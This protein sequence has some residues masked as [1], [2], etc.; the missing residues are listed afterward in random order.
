MNVPSN[1]PIRPAKLIHR[2][3]LKLSMQR[4]GVALLDDSEST[5]LAPYLE[6]M[7]HIIEPS[8]RYLE[9]AL[10]TEQPAGIK[11]FPEDQDSFY[12][13]IAQTPELQR[14]F[15]ESMNL[16]AQSANPYFLDRI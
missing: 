16:R 2:G 10:R 12:G 7:H 13:R 9:E 15:Y 1:R 6:L 4:R 5:N 8:V 14:V 3:K 11:A